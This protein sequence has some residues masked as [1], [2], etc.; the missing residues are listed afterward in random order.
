MKTE[1]ISNTNLLYKNETKKYKECIGIKDLVF[2]YDGMN[3]VIDGISMNIDYG[4]FVEITG[5]SGEGKSTFIK[6]LLGFY[7][8]ASGIYKL[9]GKY[10]DDT[11]ISE[12]RNQIAYVD[13]DCHLFQLTVKENIRLG[14]QNA[15]EEDIL[16]A[17]KLANAHDFIMNLENGYDTVINETCDNISGGQRQRIAIARAL[18]SKKEIL[19]I[20]EGTAELDSETEKMIGNTISNLKGE[21]T[22]IIITHKPVIIDNAYKK[23][24]FVAGKIE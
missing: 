1:K 19:L 10:V 3:N 11:D 14:N 21:K 24:K 9:N 23:Y 17:C 2:S 16:E 6:I 5:E 15:T 4:D 22:I 12:L 8:P 18:V 7:H 13:Q 20:D